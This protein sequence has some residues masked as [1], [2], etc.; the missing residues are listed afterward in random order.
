ML[1]YI[2]SKLFVLDH[3][4]LILLV[5]YPCIPLTSLS[6]TESFADFVYFSAKIS[7]NRVITMHVDQI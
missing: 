2:Y 7:D 4:V 3:S 1:L 5:L 6:I